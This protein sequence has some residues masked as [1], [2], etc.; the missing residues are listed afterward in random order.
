MSESSRGV[1]AGLPESQD[2]KHRTQ[3]PEDPPLRHLGQRRHGYH[4]SGS[5]WR[6]LGGAESGPPVF[7]TRSP[8]KDGQLWM[9]VEGVQGGHGV[10]PWASLV[11]RWGKQDGSLATTAAC[12]STPALAPRGG[13]KGLAQ[14][15]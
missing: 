4:L 5:H 14:V 10:T 3:E 11:M 1:T 6:S 12:T 15:P 13:T 8:C 2:S 9:G 7:W